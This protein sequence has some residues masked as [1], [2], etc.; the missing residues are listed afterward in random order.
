MKWV[1]VVA[2]IFL[3]VPSFSLSVQQQSLVKAYRNRLKRGSSFLKRRQH[4][5]LFAAISASVPANVAQSSPTDVVTEIIPPTTFGTAVL[6]WGRLFGRDEARDGTFVGVSRMRQG[7]K[8]ARTLMSWFFLFLAKVTS[9][10]SPIY[11]RNLVNTLSG[12]TTNVTPSRD[13]L[14]AMGALGFV[15]G[16]YDMTMTPYDHFPSL[17]SLNLNEIGF[18]VM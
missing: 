17:S 12:A 6:Q 18:S 2:V 7:T 9:L 10:A 11:F 16:Q 15:V 14:V 4:P 13:N 8:I 1:I 5:W 3:A